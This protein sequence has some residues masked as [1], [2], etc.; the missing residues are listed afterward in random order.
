MT[1]LELLSDYLLSEEESFELDPVED[2]DGESFWQASCGNTVCHGDT[3]LD[4]TVAL[5]REL[6]LV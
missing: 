6:G 1:P 4:A 5:L 3:P 2:D